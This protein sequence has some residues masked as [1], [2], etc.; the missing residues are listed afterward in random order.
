MTGDIGAVAKLKDVQTG[1]LLAD[2]EVARRGARHRLPGPGH[3]LRGDAEDQGRR[4]E[5]GVGDPPARR[6]GPDAAAPPRS[7]D[8]RG[9]PLGDEPD[10][11]RGRARARQAALRRRRRR[12]TR[13]ASRTWRRS[14]RRPARTA[15]TR[16]RRAAAASSAT[17]TSS[18][19]RSRAATGYEFVDKIV[20]GVI[21]QS[22]RPA[23][24]KGI[25]EAM[26]HGELAGAP[27]P[28]R[29]RP[30]RRRLVPQRRLVRD[31]VQDRRLDGVEGRVPAGRPR[32][33]RADHGA[34]GDRSR[35]GRRRRQRRPQLAP[36]PPARHGA[37]RRA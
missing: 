30:A 6:G 23:V 9:D 4:G 29:P 37:R 21:P 5:G 22:F 20:G 26:Q 19:S 33:A 18:S 2:R 35:R 24:D 32:P 25:Q 34:R 11:R 13:R 7:A 10:A 28:G 8:R 36:R 12:C 31:G 14:A 15:A 3:E 17:A 16:S 27:V 1:D